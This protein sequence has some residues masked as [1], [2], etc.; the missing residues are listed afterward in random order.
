MRRLF[1]LML[2][3]LLAVTTPNPFAHADEVEAKPVATADSN[4]EPTVA[5]LAERVRKSVVV[6]SFSGR[7][8]KQQGLGTGF[9]VSPDG[10]IVTNLHVIGEARPIEV[11]FT[12]G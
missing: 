8:G 6:V 11:Q 1:P 3:G 10:L 2:A 9:V 12:D 5:A 4:M 7:D